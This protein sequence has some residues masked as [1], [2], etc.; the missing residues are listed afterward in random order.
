MS[1]LVLWIVLSI[2]AGV[3]AG[4]RGYSFVA[5]FILSLILS[6][7]VGFISVLVRKPRP[8]AAER[9]RAEVEAA[10]SKKC[11]YC[12]ETIKAEA[13]VCRYCGRDLERVTPSG[14]AGDTDAR[15]LQWLRAQNP[16]VMEATDAQLAEY[17]Q[18]FEYK[19]RNGEL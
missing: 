16:P 19:L 14:I 18:A 11:P 13:V 7:L 3:F 4:N 6:P 15:F 5:T 1:L 8:T 17:R 9:A 10:S 2:L 12:A